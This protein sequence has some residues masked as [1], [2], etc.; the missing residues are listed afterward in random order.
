MNADRF[1][2][3]TYR[4]LGAHLARIVKVV[5]EENTA[6]EGLRAISKYYQHFIVLVGAATRQEV[7]QRVEEGREKSR[8]GAMNY[9]SRAHESEKGR[10]ELLARQQNRYANGKC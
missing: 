2:S 1:W 5:V 4:A 10:A 9:R 8:L 7:D 3:A 6:L